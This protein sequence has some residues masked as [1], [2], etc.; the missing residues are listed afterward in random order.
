MPTDMVSSPSSIAVLIQQLLAYFVRLGLIF[1]GCV[2]CGGTAELRGIILASHPAALGSIP[3][4]R[5]IVSE[6][7]LLM[8]LS[9]ISGP[10]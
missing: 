1:S 9:L 7:K 5:K 4:V 3:N 2:G 6:E 8:L 10:G